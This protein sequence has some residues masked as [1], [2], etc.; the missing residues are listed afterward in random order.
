M[1]RSCSDSRFSMKSSRFMR[2]ARRGSV[3]EISCSP[4]SSP[5]PPP[6]P[7][8]RSL[9]ISR[10]TGRNHSSPL[11]GT[12]S[13]PWA[14]E[15]ESRRERDVCCSKKAPSISRYTILEAFSLDGCTSWCRTRVTDQIWG[16]EPL[17]PCSTAVSVLGDTS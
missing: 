4:V 9:L 5:L 10:L 7:T 6:V 3:I 16:A 12:G 8:Q 11:L 13:V 2:S 17:F 14:G 15:G 1:A